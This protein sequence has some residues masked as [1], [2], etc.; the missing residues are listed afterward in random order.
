M[1]RIQRI[2]TMER[3]L[4]ASAEAIRALGEALDRYESARAGLSRIRRYY[5]SGLWLRDFEADEAGKLPE[6]LKRG[7]L[8]E[9]AVYNLLAEDRALTVQMLE[10]SAAN[11]AEG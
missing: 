10:L 3:Y 1:T 9:D 8:S 4:D 11:V 6:G 5:E 2:E 7:V